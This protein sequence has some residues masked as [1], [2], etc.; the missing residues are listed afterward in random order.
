MPG[1]NFTMIVMA[2]AQSL[3]AYNKEATAIWHGFDR[4]EHSSPALQ[5]HWSTAICIHKHIEYHEIARCH[6]WWYDEAY[7]QFSA[8]SV[9]A[10]CLSNSF[11]LVVYQLTLCY[12]KGVGELCFDHNYL[13]SPHTIITVLPLLYLM[14]RCVPGP[15]VFQH[16][17]L[18]NCERAWGRG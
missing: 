13:R 2:I 11:D 15:P 10:L 1:L 5:H 17:T 7:L 3:M 14:C 4:K 18:K 12:T 8:V 9:M 6:N 16:T